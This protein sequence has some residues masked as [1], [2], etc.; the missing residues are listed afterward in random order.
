MD[1]IANASDLDEL[2]LKILADKIKM[3]TLF[4]SMGQ[5]FIKAKA[6]T[7]HG[8]W[9]KWLEDNGEISAVTAQR[10]MKLAKLFTNESPV[11]HLGFTK[12]LILSALLGFLSKEQIEAM[13]EEV[14]EINGAKKCVS[15][16]C[17][18][19]LEALVRSLRNQKAQSKPRIKLVEQAELIEEFDFGKNLERVKANIEKLLC[20]IVENSA[21]EGNYRN[22]LYDLCE[23]TI[24]HLSPAE[25][26][27]TI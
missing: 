19:E 22:S 23:N 18:R 17:K 7:E 9:L 12:A 3:E 20:Y 16:M 2:K 8:K 14:H 4:I 15:D 5:H 21:E 1:L 13:L 24:E 26:D 10:M 11:I 27:E 25:L 6:L